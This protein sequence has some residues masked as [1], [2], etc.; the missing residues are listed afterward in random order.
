MLEEAIRKSEKSGR[1]TENQERDRV[2]QDVFDKKKMPV[3]AAAERIGEIAGL[4]H[5]MEEK[6]VPFVLVDGYE[7][8]DVIEDTGLIL[9]N[10]ND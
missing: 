1:G 4:H 6:Q 10:V 5:L 9:G 7:F 8:G 2:I 3:F